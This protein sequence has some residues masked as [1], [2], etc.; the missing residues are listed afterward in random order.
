MF[1]VLGE[2]L[3]FYSGASVGNSSEQVLEHGTA[4]IFSVLP[5][6]QSVAIFLDF[7][8]ST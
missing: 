2:M 8:E 1:W 7:Q 5:L 6:F 3:K 4:A